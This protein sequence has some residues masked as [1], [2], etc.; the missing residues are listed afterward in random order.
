[1]KARPGGRW[2]V[3]W[4]TFDPAER[5]LAPGSGSG[6]GHEAP[7]R[8]AAERRTPRCPG[9]LQWTRHR[10]RGHRG[11]GRPRRRV[12]EGGRPPP[13]PF[14]LDRQAPP[15]EGPIQGRATNTAQLVGILAPRLPE[16]DPL[17][18]SRD[19]QSARGRW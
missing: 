19:E 10:P 3:P 7:S 2:Q 12:G 5:I 6:L 17:R 4:R 13:R 1:M 8:Q 16:P 18:D 11:R 15:G 14:T 9:Q